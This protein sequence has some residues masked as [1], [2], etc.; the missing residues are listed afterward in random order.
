MGNNGD[1]LRLKLGQG[2]TTWDAVA[3]GLGCRMPDIQSSI[4]I[5]YN[6]ELN[7]WR[8]DEKLR[9]NILDLSVVN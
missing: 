9:L 2:N 7:K 3:F 8:G 5:V 1:H 4:D 6:L